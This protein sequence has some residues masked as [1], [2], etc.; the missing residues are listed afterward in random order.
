[1]VG[2]SNHI[3][4]AARIWT[5]GLMGS[6]CAFAQFNTSGTANVSV[7]VAAEAAI[8]IGSSSTSLTSSGTLFSN[9]AG[10]TNFTYKIR[11]TQTTGSGNIQLQ[12]TTDF[13]GTGG[14]K[15]A[16]PPTVGDTLTYTCTVASPAT[17]CS[18]S[19]TASTTSQTSVATF[20]ADAH[21]A[22]AGNSG[23][24]SWT[25]TNDPQYKTGSY[26]ATATFTISAT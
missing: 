22:Q 18:S 17:A 11:T 16:T 20:G 8:S 12:I 25:L 21:S 10:S 24:V 7:T 4:M 26:T 9:Y 5:I 6:A 15:V 14:P 23:S 19:Q 1:M 2:T 3:R 13:N